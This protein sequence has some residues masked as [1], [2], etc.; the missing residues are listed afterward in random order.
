MLLFAPVAYSMFEDWA[1]LVNVVGTRRTGSVF[2]A[3][4]ALGI[5][6]VETRGINESPFTP[7]EN[8]RGVQLHLTGSGSP[9][10]SL[11]KIPIAAA[12]RGSS[13]TTLSSASGSS[14]EGA[15]P[16]TF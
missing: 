4:A 7:N 6:P 12:S 5:C 15:S 10:A 16:E 8:R 9:P 3:A 14:G 11:L 1:K 2:T 13:R